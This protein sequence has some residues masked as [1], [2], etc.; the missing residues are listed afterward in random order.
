M[1]LIP[2]KLSAVDE[3]S[4]QPVTLTKEESVPLDIGEAGPPQRTHMFLITKYRLRR[5]RLA[6]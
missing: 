5:K 1:G 2:S 3:Q 6:Q 4:T